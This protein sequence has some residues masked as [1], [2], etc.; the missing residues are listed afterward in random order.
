MEYFLEILI[1]SDIYVKIVNILIFL[2][3]VQYNSSK[4]CILKKILK[5]KL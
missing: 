2:V 5:K 4:S 1:R 3:H